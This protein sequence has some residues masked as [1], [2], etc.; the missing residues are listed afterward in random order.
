MWNDI[1]AKSKVRLVWQEI[2]A[3]TEQHGPAFR[4][5]LTVVK[6]DCAKSGHAGGVFI[7]Y[8]NVTDLDMDH[9]ADVVGRM[10]A[11]LQKRHQLG[12]ILQTYSGDEAGAS[13]WF[14]HYS[15]EWHKLV[16]LTALAVSA[17]P[18]NTL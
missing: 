5:E 7:I 12:P 15:D 17:K 11:Q 6:L 14:Q 2:L 3:R 16:S 1:T 9:P 4:A 13:R 10:V 18:E 8:R